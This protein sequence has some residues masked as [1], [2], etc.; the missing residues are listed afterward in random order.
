M[1]DKNLCYGFAHIDK[2]FENPKVVIGQ[3]I[4]GHRIFFLNTGTS[5]FNDTLQY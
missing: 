2:S 1:L 3:Y 5:P 4:V